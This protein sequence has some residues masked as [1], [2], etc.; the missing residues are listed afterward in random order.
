MLSNTKVILGLLCLIL[1][2]PSIASELRCGWLHNPTPGNWWLNDSDGEWLISTQGGPYLD[3]KSIDKLPEI[4]D[5]EFVK[6]NVNY[7]Y[8]CVCL[9]VTIDQKE[10]RILKIHSKGKQQL[11]KVCLEDRDLPYLVR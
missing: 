9:E 10:M 11:L 3:D 2:S 7:G 5:D 4:N 6:T 8:S 1:T